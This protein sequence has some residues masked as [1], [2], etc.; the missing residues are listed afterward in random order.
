M[1]SIDIRQ[2]AI[3]NGASL[4][5]ESPWLG[6]ASFT[7]ETRAY[8]HGR[9]EEIAE[10][11]RRVQRKLLTV[12][13]G[14]SGLG[15]TSILRAGVVP[16]LR[17]EGYCPVYVRLDYGAGAPVPAEQIKQA[18]ARAGQGGRTPETGESLWEFLHQ[19]G[20]EPRDASGRAP[21][22]LLIFD[23]F[24]EVFTLAQS[25][26]AGRQR[27]QAF[28]QQLADLVEN[29]PPADLEARIERDDA[30]AEKFDFARADY[31]VLI[32]LREDYLAHL[33][34]LK[35]IMPSVTQNR[36]RLARMTGAQALAAVRGPGMG[37][38]SEEVA[39]QIVSFVSGAKDPATA[40][41]EPSLLSLVCRELNNARLAQGR[42]EISA[43]LLAGSRD[44]ILSEFYERA[45]ADQPAGVRHF[46]EDTLLTDSGYRESIA[47]E[48][49][50]KGFAAIGAPAGTLETLVGRRLLRVEERL[51]VRRVELTHDVLCGVVKAS[52]DT[53]R[54]REAKEAAEAQ[55]AA[56]RAK[57]AETRRALTQSRRVAAVGVTLAIIAAAGAV[58]GFVNMRRADRERAAAE[59]AAEQARA[60]QKAAQ[61]AEEKAQATQRLADDARAEA[62]K[63]VTFLIDDFYEELEH[64]GRLETIAKL[65]QQAVSYYDGLPPELRTRET[66]RN[67]A[68]ALA[69]LGAMSYGQGKAEAGREMVATALADFQRLRAEGDTSEANAIGLVLAQRLDLAV[70]AATRGPGSS[71]SVRDTLQ[72]AVEL[73]RAAASAP[74]STA[75]TKK[76][77]AQ[78]L[79]ALGSHQL[80]SSTAQ[81]VSRE[82]IAPIEEARKILAD[83]GALD[84]SDLGAAAMHA[85]LTSTLAQYA[86][87][88]GGFSRDA[89]DEA[90]RYNRETMELADRVLAKRPGDHTTLIARIRAQFYLGEVENGRGNLP[91]ALE[92][93]LAAERGCEE[94]L[95][96]NPS[97]V[98]MWNS[99]VSVR[100]RS[101]ELL[102]QQ[103]R[104]AEALTKYR[105]GL[106]VGRQQT[107][108]QQTLSV[109]PNA[110]LSQAAWEGR[111]RN[112]AMA[113]AALRA[114]AELRERVEREQRFR[115]AANESWRLNYAATARGVRH[116]LGDHEAVLA[117]GEKTLRH[118]DQLMKADTFS[119]A[120]KNNFERMRATV[121]HDM[122]RAQMLLGRHAEAEASQRKAMEEAGET[123]DAGSL[124]RQWLAMAVAK[125]GRSQ[126][127]LTLIE[128]SLTHYRELVAKGDSSLFT[129]WQLVRAL[130]AH[131]I[132]QPE[133]PAGHARRRAALD[134]AEKHLDQLSD[135]ALQLHDSLRFRE[136]IAEERAKLPAK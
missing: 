29:R 34:T 119:A 17:E 83:V 36:M 55:L 105:A 109:L 3:G 136:W 14:Q 89:D 1:T 69:R 85:Y 47:E 92:L 97:V 117:D 78:A 87:A 59:A 131:A 112:R 2:S 8:F 22:P 51:D 130:Y 45:L 108:S 106:D 84:L 20:E 48:R 98:D 46:I 43:D 102:A 132:A 19:R 60:A 57:E 95:R 41:V 101:G 66:T 122:G 42:G 100:L 56:T 99:L 111:R 128:P 33:E 50:R 32:A 82:T 70:N 94:Y 86:T 121:R 118:I 127:A 68:L 76:H 63:L 123:T 125:Q 13:F 135:E 88:F 58:F 114:A 62:E 35:N 6:L 16:K 110:A 120:E 74:G 53:R 49:V 24:E 10:L 113:E 71:A 30:L 134:E 81:T 23:Q 7:E 67:R 124:R 133:N 116:A 126:E 15:K 28:L 129:C 104:I 61:A 11:A 103:G 79:A 75:R 39:R 77:Y 25:D 115:P 93:S 37:L 96:L 38:V 26:D 9:D 27:A 40:E 90:E 73:L 52:R 91:A 4:S 80:A 12:L 72:G 21:T 31:R 54:E 107:T 5:S 65:T 64:T 18:I 44:T